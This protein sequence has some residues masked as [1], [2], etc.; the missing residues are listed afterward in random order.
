MFPFASTTFSSYFLY[1]LST[2]LHTYPYFSLIFDAISVESS[3]L[4]FSP[5]SFNICNVNYVI[6]LPAK[7]ML[8]T[9]LPMTYPSHT[10]KTWVTPSPASM[11]VPVK[12]LLSSLSSYAS[13]PASWANSARVACTPINAR[14]AMSSVLGSSINLACFFI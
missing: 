8:F 6:S 13:G 5:R 2:S 1:S 4:N 14:L 11:T 9:Q 10:G 12:S 3:A 7:G